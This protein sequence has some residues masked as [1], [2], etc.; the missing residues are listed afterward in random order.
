MGAYNAIAIATCKPLCF[1]YFFVSPGVGW[2]LPFYK[3]LQ[4]AIFCAA[5]FQILLPVQ[6]GW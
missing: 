1:I 4:L 2:F 6:A 3:G 5:W